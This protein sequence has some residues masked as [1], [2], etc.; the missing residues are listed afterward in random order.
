VIN[1]VFA[2]PHVAGAEASG[3][4]KFLQSVKRANTPLTVRYGVADSGISP[5]NL[6]LFR[7]Q[8]IVEQESIAPDP[9]SQVLIKAMVIESRTSL[10][11]KDKAPHGSLKPDCLPFA[12]AAGPKRSA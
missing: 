1:H 12:L 3:H 10:P 7:K 8:Q 11:A 2:L 5:Q 9:R 4:C 6:D